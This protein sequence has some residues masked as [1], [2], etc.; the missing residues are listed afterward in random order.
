MFVADA[1]GRVLDPKLEAD[2]ADML[3]ATGGL[4]V[5]EIGTPAHIVA[6]INDVF[7]ARFAVHVEHPRA[8]AVRDDDH[9]FLARS[10]CPGLDTV[11]RAA[12]LCRHGL[13]LGHS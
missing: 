10:A 8:A 5:G 6:Q 9:A 2:A 1:G 7:T 3:T 11:F 4:A 13:T 12:D